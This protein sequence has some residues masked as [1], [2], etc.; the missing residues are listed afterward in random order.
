MLFSV[1]ITI[2][3]EM[4]FAILPMSIDKLHQTRQKSHPVS[5]TAAR[6]NRAFESRFIKRRDVCFADGM[7]LPR[8]QEELAAVLDTRVRLISDAQR[9]EK[10]DIKRR[11][12]PAAVSSFLYVS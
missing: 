2:S 9:D 12:G 11:E 7:W 8:A 3:K 10:A 1:I 6:A 5:T 4:P